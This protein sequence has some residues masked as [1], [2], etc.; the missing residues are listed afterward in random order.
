MKLFL[1]SVLL[2]L[3]LALA[4][5]ACAQTTLPPDRIVGPGFAVWLDNGRYQIPI[6]SISASTPQLGSTAIPLSPIAAQALNAG[7]GIISIT[8]QAPVPNGATIS[9]TDRAGRTVASCVVQSNVFACTQ[10]LAG[11]DFS[12]G[13]TLNGSGYY[14]APLTYTLAITV[15]Y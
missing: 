6:Y 7:S 2:W 1:R 14:G 10:Q 13:L 5:A 12:G 8:P 3:A 15:S 4:L 11:G 9:V